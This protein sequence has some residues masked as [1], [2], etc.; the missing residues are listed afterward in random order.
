LPRVLLENLARGQSIG[1]SVRGL[2]LDQGLHSGK[3][4]GNRL[5]LRASERSDRRVSLAKTRKKYTKIHYI[6]NLTSAR[7]D[8]HGEDGGIFIPSSSPENLC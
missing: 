6:I 8:A 7:S 3:N 5:L 1:P 4:R 2:V